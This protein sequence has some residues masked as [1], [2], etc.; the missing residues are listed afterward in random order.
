M[1]KTL[2]GD[3]LA[4]DMDKMQQ[5]IVFL[6]AETHRYGAL[7]VSCALR[8]LMAKREREDEELKFE[9]TTGQSWGG[10]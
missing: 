8:G 7:R 2:N 4:S 6:Q 3:Q 5:R 9:L 1:V 10:W